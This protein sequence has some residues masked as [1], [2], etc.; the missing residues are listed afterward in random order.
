MT[1]N[2]RSLIAQAEASA[3]TPCWPNKNLGWDGPTIRNKK[4]IPYAFHVGALI[5][6]LSFVPLVEVRAQAVPRELLPAYLLGRRLFHET[7][8]TN[9]GASYAVSCAS[10]HS[11]KL[12]GP[13]RPA[14]ADV[15]PRSLIPE[16]S[17]RE[18]STT[19]RNAPTLLDVAMMERLGHN[20][21][22]TS[23]EELVA[24]KLLSRQFGWSKSRAAHA[25]EQIISVVVG[26]A[27]VDEGSGGVYA[28]QFQQAYGASLNL[29]P[30]QSVVDLIGRAIV[31]YLRT[32]RTTNTAPWDAFVSMNRI[33][34]HP[35]PEEP[36]EHYAGRVLGRIGNQEGR[37]QVKLVD[38]FN[39]VA[40]RGFQTFFR[41]SGNESVGN[42]V[43]C[44]VPL[45]FTNFK[46][47]NTGVSQVAYEQVHGPGRFN[48]LRIPNGT[49]A[50]RPSADFLLAP[51]LDDPRRADLGY[52]NYVDLGNA[53]AHQEGESSAAVLDRMVGA[54]KTPTLRNLSQSAPYMHNGAYSAIGKT[55]AAIVHISQLARAGRLRN[56]DA[57]YLEVNLT[58]SDIQ[59]LTAFLMSLNEVPPE[60]F[61]ELLLS[62]QAHTGEV[63]E[64]RGPN[65]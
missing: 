20:G 43:S 8:F 41:T 10:C 18:K 2:K 19:R 63:D 29:L 48:E 36:P 23:L 55:V 32:L 59:P 30:P 50:N 47:H 6:A 27:G 24:S 52:W 40:Y 51:S 39:V 22:F 42:C 15:T 21:R 34:P 60:D 65:R 1:C 57:E 9:P 26:D 3:A 25:Q 5:L 46:F 33:P 12:R 4:Q 44:H 28:A 49:N 14:F 13:G 61:R 7:R 56:I 38:G 11:P 54:F 64:P 35:N 45:M 53:T 16:L 58:E 17:L 37:L 31:D 62:A